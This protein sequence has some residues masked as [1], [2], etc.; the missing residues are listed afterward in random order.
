MIVFDKCTR[1]FSVVE[2]RVYGDHWENYSHNRG[3]NAARDKSDRYDHKINKAR[4]K[5]EDRSE[6]R[7]RLNNMSGLALG[8]R[9][10]NWV[11]GVGF[12]G[13]V[14]ANK[15]ARLEKQKTRFQAREDYHN[16]AKQINLKHKERV[17]DYDGVKNI[18]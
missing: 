9:T 1:R 12:K 13:D 15:L 6:V 14:R 5:V 16:N 2:D 8:T 11:H 4:W 7:R 18:E 3:I 10:K 17:G